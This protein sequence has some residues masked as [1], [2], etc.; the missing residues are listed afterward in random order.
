MGMSVKTA[1]LPNSQ[2]SLEIS[3]G[4]E[5]C[6]AA[7]D[8]VLR[9]LTKRANI[10]G[11]R[12]GSVP[13]QIV[14]NQYGKSTILAS[15]C[16]EVIEKSINKAL[17]D[18]GVHAIGQAM[19]DEEGGV[20]TVIRN[21]D[22]NSSLSFKVK[23]DVWPEANFTEPYTDLEI[24]A[25]EALFNESLI[26]KTLHDL[27]QKESFSVLAPE[28]TAA[29]L[30]QSLAADLVGYYRNEDESK[31][32]KLPDI[33]DGTGV[34]ISMTEGKFMPGF[35]EGLLGA[36][37]GEK[38]D[39]HVD[40]PENNPRKELAGAKAV[41]E[42]TVHAI[43][44]VVLPELNDDFAKQVSED[45]T[46]EEFRETIR[47]RLGVEAEA[48]L[49][50]NTNTAIDDKLASII[51]VD[52]PESL[53]ENQCKNKF[54][55]MLASFKDNGMNDNQVKAMVTKENYELYKTRSRGNVEK[56]LKVNFAISKIA[57]DQGIVVNKQE[58]EDQIELIRAELKGQEM[59]ED[60]ARDQVEAQLEKNLVLQFLKE[61]AKVTIVPKKVE[62]ASK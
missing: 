6:K 4:S 28:G 1:P 49:E 10:K 17:K 9:E 8:S 13:R 31:G 19:V 15:A 34:E 53:V 20:E 36:K 45:S 41:F 56:S 32:E 42:V 55:N 22:P 26:D 14:I 46:L 39:V 48:A 38:R 43:K 35:V 40:F 18:T 16:E 21:Y 25:E 5:E 59:D 54:A 62:N 33:A 61:T 27:R 7:W 11:F 3:V 52:L 30:G 51:E 2:V 50:K 24:E 57:K 23:I 29:K 60:K 47:K 37:A 44:D 58:V 12:K